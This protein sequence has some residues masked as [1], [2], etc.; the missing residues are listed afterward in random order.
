VP[1]AG[2]DGTHVVTAEVSGYVS[3]PPGYTTRVEE[4][5]VSVVEVRQA[6]T[7]ALST[8]PFNSAR[9]MPQPP[10]TRGTEYANSALASAPAWRSTEQFCKA[11]LMPVGV[12]DVEIPFSP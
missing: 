2:K 3:E 1:E 8:W 12:F 11:Q 10:H 9:S 4:L 5:A 6:T 7:T